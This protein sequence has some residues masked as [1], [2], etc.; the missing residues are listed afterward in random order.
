MKNEYDTKQG[1]FCLSQL[2]YNCE[3]Y[4]TVILLSGMYI[5]VKEKDVKM[6]QEKKTTKSLDEILKSV[7]PDSIGTYLNENAGSLAEDERPYYVYMKEVLKRKGI[8]Q[9]RVYMD[10]GFTQSFGGKIFRGEKKMSNRDMVV[11]LCLAGH[12]NLEETNKTLKLCGYSP[13][14]SIIRR[15]AVLIV[16]VNTRIYDIE[17]V[18]DLLA[19]NGFSILENT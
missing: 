9:S 2:W 14:Y 16:A 10:A 5:T 18:N 1:L 3:N 12:F 11:R 6:N 8:T 17:S 15:D 13:L 7:K 19:R 4:I